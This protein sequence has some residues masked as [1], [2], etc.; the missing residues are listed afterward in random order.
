MVRFI[1]RLY[2]ILIIVDAV[3]SYFPQ[4]RNYDVVRFI[5]KCPD[6]TLKPIRR[7][8]P[9]DMPFDASPIIVIILLNLLMVLW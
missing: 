1:I 4:W 9:S 8:L 3:L 2:I 6:F 7:H 5:K